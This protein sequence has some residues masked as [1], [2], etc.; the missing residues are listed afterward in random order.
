MTGSTDPARVSIPRLDTIRALCFL[1]VFGLHAFWT[2]DQVTFWHPL[3]RKV[4][5]PLFSNGATGVNVFFV[6][7]G[8]LITYLLIQEKRVVGR[9][10]VPRFWLRRALRIWPLYYVVVIIGFV[11]VPTLKQRMGL[12]PDTVQSGWSYLFFYN[13]IPMAHG[14]GGNSTVLS[15]LW[16]IAVEEQFYLVWPVLLAVLPV[17]GYPFLFL[18]VVAASVAFKASCTDELMQVWHTFSCMG[19]L[20]TGGLCALVAASVRGRAWLSAMPLWGIILLH[21]MWLWIYVPNRWCVMPWQLVVEPVLFAVVSGGIILYQGFG[22]ASFLRFGFS[23][24]LEWLGRISFGLYCLHMVAILAVRQIWPRIT[25]PGFWSESLF[26]PICSLALAVGLAYAS[27]RWLE[28]P[29]LRLK[30]R[31]AHIHRDHA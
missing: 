17:R 8:F 4:Y 16:S 30:D 11:L 15:V 20:A 25:P 13:N 3:W 23:P 10:D 5:S 18:A 24:M 28:R 27:H 22:R 31:F 7:S 12:P 9:I 19:D 6:L 26:M 14:V 1:M 21:A 29:F 2:D